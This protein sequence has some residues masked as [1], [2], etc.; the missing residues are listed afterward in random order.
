LRSEVRLRSVSSLAIGPSLPLAAGLFIAE[1][2][3][4]GAGH[5]VW[6]AIEVRRIYLWHSYLNSSG[7]VGIH[8]VAPESP[9]TPLVRPSHSFT[10]ARSY[11][12]CEQRR[13]LTL[14]AAVLFV[15]CR[16]AIVT[17]RLLCPGEDRRQCNR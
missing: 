2:H 13:D 5:A 6:P 4:R 9:P 17:R 3:R 10:H 14:L 8:A 16:P 1:S 12:N 11:T 7:I 15:V